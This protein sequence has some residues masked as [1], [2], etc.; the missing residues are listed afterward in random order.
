MGPK[1]TLIIADE[2][3]QQIHIKSYCKT[4]ECLVTSCRCL[5]ACRC[6]FVGLCVLPTIPPPCFLSIN[7]IF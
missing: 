5:P 1:G 6:A 4:L 3:E 2:H 7:T